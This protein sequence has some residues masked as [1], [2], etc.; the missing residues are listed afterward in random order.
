MIGFADA[1][2]DLKPDLIILLGDR[3]ELLAASFRA[4]NATIPIAHIL[5]GETTE[6]AIDESIR[7][8]I[9]K[10]SW[11]HL[12]LMMRMLVGLSNLGNPNRV[13]NVGGLGVDLINKS[14]LLEKRGDKKDV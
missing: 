13:F 3:Y 12:Q 5:G 2:E 7:H 8:S 9:T 11:F 14:K 4:L 1:I 6:G 10:M